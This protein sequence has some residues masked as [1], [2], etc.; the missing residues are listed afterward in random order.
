MNR[1]VRNGLA[2]ATMAGGLFL[3]GQAAASAARLAA[4]TASLI[5]RGSP[6]WALAMAPAST[7]N[8]VASAVC[9]AS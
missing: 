2:V 5:P 4:R 1:T 8:T 3:L 9:H 6:A 7:E